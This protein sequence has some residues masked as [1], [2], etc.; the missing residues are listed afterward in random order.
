MPD[1]PYKV[2]VTALGSSG[3]TAQVPFTV[4]GTATSVQNNNGT[5]QARKWAACPYLS[6]PL[7]RPEA[8][9]VPNH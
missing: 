3:S 5:V 1:G 6:A 8:D 4:T 7:Y 9:H 2:S